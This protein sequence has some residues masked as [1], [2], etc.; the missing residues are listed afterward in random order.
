M[1][2][3]EVI[4]NEDDALEFRLTQFIDWMARILLFKVFPFNKIARRFL[5]MGRLRYFG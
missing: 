2:G 1:I 3:R 4:D 5:Q